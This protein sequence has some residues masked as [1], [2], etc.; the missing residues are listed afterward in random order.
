MGTYSAKH[1]IYGQL[2]FHFKSTLFKFCQKIA[3]LNLSIHLFQMDIE[4]LAGGNFRP[5]R[6]EVYDR[7]RIEVRF[8]DFKCRCYLR[9]QSVSNIAD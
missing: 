8:P 7:D 6:N 5:Y 3:M 4:D 1:D 9:S 2:H